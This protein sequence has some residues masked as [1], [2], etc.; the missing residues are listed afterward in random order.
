M[1]REA[2][3]MVLG[4]MSSA[5]DEEIAAWLRAEWSKPNAQERMWSLLDRCCHGGRDCAPPREPFPEIVWN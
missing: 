4:Q 3:L 5:F 2:S 1:R